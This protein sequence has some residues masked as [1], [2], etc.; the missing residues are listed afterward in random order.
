MNDVINYLNKLFNTNERVV[1]GISGGPDSMLLLNLLVNSNIDNQDIIVA[2][3]NHNVRSVSDEEEE[4]VKSVC[5]EYGVV[6]HSIKLPK[7]TGNNFE[8]WARERRYEFY[9]KLIDNYNAK[10]LMTAHHGDDLVETILM[11]IVRGSNL[12][13]YSGFA[14]EEVRDKYILV[15]PLISK[16]KDEIIFYN[17]KHN[18]KYVID[19]SNSSLLYT[20]NRYRHNILRKFKEEDPNVHFK[21]LEFSEN[22]KDISNF[23]ER[24]INIEKN[25]VFDTDKII[26]DKIKL[27]E[28]VVQRQFIYNWLFDNYQDRISCINRSHID[29]IISLIYNERPNIS[30]DLPGNKQVVKSYNKLS[31]GDNKTKITDKKIE[32]ENRVVWNKREIIRV[33]NSDLSSNYVIYLNSDDIKLPL[34]VRNRKDGDRIKIKNMDHYKKVKDVF[35]KDNKK[36]Y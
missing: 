35:E 24:Y 8:K 18:I 25:K 4:F 16:T 12:K 9:E 21:F 3:I 13:G 1:V 2:H 5:T 23:F 14:K 7:K 19:E 31:I 17:D 22:L 29:N 26:I 10:Y 28:K 11:K 32:I 27:Y 33:N 15:R 30:L 20:R 6:F 36:G 34:Y